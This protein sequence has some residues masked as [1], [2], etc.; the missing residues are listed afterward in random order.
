MLCFMARA[1]PYHN[2]KK[3]AAI[4][5]KN[6]KAKWGIAAEEDWKA[7]DATTPISTVKM[8]DLERLE[9]FAL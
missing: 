4:A 1:M 9:R 8:S 3:T 7:I 5:V 2:K 6:Q